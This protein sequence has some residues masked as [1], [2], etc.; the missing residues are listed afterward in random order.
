M[1]GL[2]IAEREI[3]MN[4]L[5]QCKEAFITSSTKNI[6][7]VTVIDGRVVGNGT[8]GEVSRVLYQELKELIR[9]N[10]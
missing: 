2:Q 4:D 9:L 8:A 5:Q 1:E 10:N 3:N 7:P 6:L